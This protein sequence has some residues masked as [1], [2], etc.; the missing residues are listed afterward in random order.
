MPRNR[1]GVAPAR[2]GI[3]RPWLSILARGSRL[4]P[5]QPL[6][7]AAL[8]ACLLLSSSC[9]HGHEQNLT[10]RQIENRVSPA[11]VLIAAEYDVTVNVAEL[12]FDEDRLEKDVMNAVNGRDPSEDELAKLT[13]T[14]LLGSPSRYFH[15]GS[16]RQDLKK[17]LTSIGT[18]FI[19]TPDG[20]ILTSAH[21][22]EP[23]EAEIRMKAIESISELVSGNIEGLNKV[24][25]MLA[26]GK[27]MTAEEQTKVIRALAQEY[28]KEATFSEE[29]EISAIMGFTTRAGDVD[30]A[31][32]TC[33]PI[34]IG[35]KDSGQ[36]VAILKIKEEEE[37]LP[38]VPLRSG[39]NTGD[40]IFILG[41]PL[42][43]AL[44]LDFNIKSLL[45]PSW[46]QGHIN[47]FKQT[48]DGDRVMLTETPLK[49]GNSGGPVL[50]SNARAI[51]IATFSVSDPDESGRSQAADFIV[52]ISVAESM[53]Q[54][55]HVTPRQSSFTAK[56]LDGLR[57]YESHRDQAALGVFRTLSQERPE[58]VAIRNIIK[59]IE[60]PKVTGR[61]QIGN[62]KLSPRALASF[63]VL[64]VIIFVLAIIVYLMRSPERDR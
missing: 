48:E 45:T 36:D 52:P 22:V 18:G 40:E 15:A 58:I 37:D 34:K 46:S 16:E 28:A 39:G 42:E 64:I 41:F 63:G 53:L 17:D 50:D 31:H 62:N 7:I 38:T 29:H 51:G 2:I 60:T 26:H 23:D 61:G 59:E 27:Q 9:R 33:K 35:K 4:Y 47:G 56:Y 13:F 19:V 25:R 21:V 10:A 54:E 20:Y 55:L 49:P 24:I 6:G 43:M 44:N 3:L 12:D 5:I 57:L 8:V 14:V 30:P 32:W 1:P 11:T